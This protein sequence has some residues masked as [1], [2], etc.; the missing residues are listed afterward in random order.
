MRTK[1]ERKAG[2]GV[3]LGWAGFKGSGVDAY[4][5]TCLSA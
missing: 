2:G 5:D 1:G 4:T 3:G